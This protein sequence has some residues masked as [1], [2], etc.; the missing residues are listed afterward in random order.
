MKIPFDVSATEIKAAME[1]LKNG[2]PLP[3]SWT[4]EG[5]QKLVAIS[6]WT[7]LVNSPR[8]APVLTALMRINDRHAQL[9][10]MEPAMDSEQ[11]Q[12]NIG[13]RRPTY[14]LDDI[15]QT[16]VTG[17]L[18]WLIDEVVEYERRLDYAI[19]RYAMNGK[20]ELE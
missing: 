9:A 5:L 14:T 15:T 1:S 20:F 7:H 8:F 13:M 10:T 11:L 3:P 12:R 18:H 2:E 19:R 4:P 6:A 16:Y 17:G